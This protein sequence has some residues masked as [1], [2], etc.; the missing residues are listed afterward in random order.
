M[1]E[2][3]KRWHAHEPE[4]CAVGAPTSHIGAEVLAGGDFH[5]VF[6]REPSFVQLQFLLAAVIEAIEA[7]DEWRWRLGGPGGEA[8]GRGYV[9]NAAFE[10]F[11]GSGKTPAEALLRAYVRAL[12]AQAE[13]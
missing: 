8:D 2:L 10:E 11:T 12:E 1:T 9:L 4:R 13:A 3:L 5:S 7:R 6:W